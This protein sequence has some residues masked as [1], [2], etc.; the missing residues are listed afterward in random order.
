MAVD[1]TKAS[2]DGWGELSG[3]SME[4]VRFHRNRLIRRRLKGIILAL[5]SQPDKGRIVKK[6]II[7]LSTRCSEGYMDLFELLQSSIPALQI[8]LY[9]PTWVEVEMIPPHMTD[10]P[11]PETY[12]FQDIA[13]RSFSFVKLVSLRLTVQFHPVAN[14]TRLLSLCP[15]LSE[16]HLVCPNDVSERQQSSFEVAP[17]IQLENLESLDITARGLSPLAWLAM[18]MPVAPNLKHAAVRRDRTTPDITN[19]EFN[20]AQERCAP[21]IKAFTGL[22]SLEWCLHPVSIHAFC[23]SGMEDSLVNVA[24]YSASHTPAMDRLEVSISKTV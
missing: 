12:F 20:R 4:H 22:H 2:R 3:Y 13:L 8:K 15:Q 11:T 9:N 1:L 24:T 14:A 18:L 17:T 21:I 10:D 6:V 7:E 19:R 16:L 23:G 5:D